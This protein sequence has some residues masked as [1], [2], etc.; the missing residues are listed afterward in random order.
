MA[1][2]PGR[3]EMSALLY[4]NQGH[5]EKRCDVVVLDCAPTAESQHFD[6]ARIEFLKG[7]LALLDARIEPVS[8][9]RTKGETI[10]VE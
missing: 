10:A 3:E 1:I 6:T 5:R 4:V 8:K 9:P 2:F 7:L